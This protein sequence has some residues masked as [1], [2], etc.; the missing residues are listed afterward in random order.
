M[1]FI[2]LLD[3]PQ[4]F[5]PDYVKGVD[6]FIKQNNMK[7]LG[8]PFLFL[9]LLL[10]SCL[11]SNLNFSDAIDRN[12]RKLDTEEQRRDAEFLVEAMDYNIL[13]RELATRASENAYSRVVTDFAKENLDDHLLMAERMVQVAKEKKFALPTNIEE[14]HQD[15]LQDL[16]DASK[17]NIDRVYLN[18]IGLVHERA[19]R[20][21][22]EA[23]VNANDAEVRA[24]AAAQLDILRDHSRK[25]IDIRK[26]LI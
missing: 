11:P 23:A 9:I 17:Q 19:L 10:Q 2:I 3:K 6:Y 16:K 5:Q 7:S 4:P 24:Y 14:R 21:Y 22:E 20:L 15:L 12:N 26:E 13:L 25:A 8:V 18:I 1:I